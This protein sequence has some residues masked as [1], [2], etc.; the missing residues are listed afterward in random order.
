MISGLIDEEINK[1]VDIQQLLGYDTSLIDEDFNL[2]ELHCSSILSDDVAKNL[3]S[4]QKSAVPNSTAYQ[5][6]RWSKALNAFL[7][8]KGMP[9]DFKD[10]SKVD[11]DKELSYF[12][13]ELKTIDGHLFL[14]HN[15]S[16]DTNRR[17]QSNA[18]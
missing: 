3:D 14:R 7:L 9:T 4:L 16:Q 1:I 17:N 8:E 11:I 6:A 13:S 2:E 12:Y 5:Q 18:T 10:M 15:A